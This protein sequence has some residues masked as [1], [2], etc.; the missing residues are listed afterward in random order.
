MA[1]KDYTPYF[2][3]EAVG[4]RIGIVSCRL[5][6]AAVVVGEKDFDAPAR[7]THFHGEQGDLDADMGIVE[8]DKHAD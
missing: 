3:V 8:V 7:H 1:A 6:G 5:C 2:E 4:Q